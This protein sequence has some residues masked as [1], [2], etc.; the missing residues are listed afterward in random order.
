MCCYAVED[1]P[2]QKEEK[3]RTRTFS[4]VF[5]IMKTVMGWSIEHIFEFL[6][7]G[8]FTRWSSWEHGHG[9]ADAVGGFIQVSCCVLWMS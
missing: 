6:W 9:S 5:P 4:K 2:K 3:I 7:I 1:K 8:I